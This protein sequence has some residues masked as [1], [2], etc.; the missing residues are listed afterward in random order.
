MNKEQEQMVCQEMKLENIL[1]FLDVCARRGWNELA[2]FE[3][4]ISSAISGDVFS[5]RGDRTLAET[6]IDGRLYADE[7][8]VVEEEVAEW[9]NCDDEEDVRTCTL[10]ELPGDVE[11]SYVQSV[12]P[13]LVRFYE[14]WSL[15]EKILEAKNE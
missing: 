13:A 14:D 3:Q 2:F 5:K 1:Q 11:W 12:R 10:S 4:A 9:M 6:I 7:F 15:T 8:V